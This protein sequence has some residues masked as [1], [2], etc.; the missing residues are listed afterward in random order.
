MTPDDNCSLDL[1]GADCD[2]ETDRG[3]TALTMAAVDY[4]DVS[5][6][7]VYRSMF[8][9]P[10]IYT[11]ALT[12]EDEEGW[13]DT[14]QNPTL[15]LSVDT[16]TTPIPNI[17]KSGELD[18]SFETGQTTSYSITVT[19]DGN[20]DLHNVEVADTLIAVVT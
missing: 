13:P 14:E 19:N 2:D 10:G 17:T 8:L 18:D 15:S 20:V 1:D 5:G 6:D 3:D 7:W 9:Y 16:I 4:D 12:C 11:E